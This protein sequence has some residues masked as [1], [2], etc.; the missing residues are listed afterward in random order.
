MYGLE[1]SMFIA[2]TYSYFYIPVAH[3]QHA[4]RHIAN[5]RPQT[6]PVFLGHT[7]SHLYEQYINIL[8]LFCLENLLLL[9]YLSY[10]SLSI[11][12]FGTAIA[13]NTLRN[14]AHNIQ[15]RTGCLVAEMYE[16]ISLQC[17]TLGL[18]TSCT[19]CTSTSWLKE[20]TQVS[21]RWYI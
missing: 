5:L 17:G 15:D 10:I 9:S 6:Q 8:T 11:C 1:V 7:L 4:T 2:D 20:K 19:I 3:T 14:T 18:G 13:L 16:Y 12:H 21:P